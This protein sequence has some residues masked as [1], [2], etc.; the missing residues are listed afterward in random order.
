MKGEL[1]AIYCRLSVEDAHK[2]D[3]QSESIRNQRALLLDYAEGQGWEVVRVYADEDYSGLREDRPAFR[4]MLADAQ[5]G[6]F[7]ILLCKT[8]SRF[9]RNAQTAEKYLH[10]LF[11][12]WG[13]RFVTVV[14][15]VDTAYRAN[16]KA[17]QINSLV[18]EW[19][20]EELSENIRAVLRRK[21]QA[22]QFL[23]NYPPY[24]YRRDDADRHHLLPD[25][26]TAPVVARI[27][28]R[29]LAGGSCRKI[30]AGLTAEGVPTP[31]QLKK[32]RGEDLGRRCAAAWSSSTVRKIL[33]NPLYLGHMVQGREEKISFKEKKTRTLPQERWIIVEHTHE[34][35]VEGAVFEEVAR[36]MAL[37]RRSGQAEA[38]RR[39]TT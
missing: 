21:M 20:C 28:S 1:A 17:R 25:A 33:K 15:H 22:G 19:Y 31:S 30:A 6:Q 24:G 34:P 29:Y 37:R 35:L 2:E 3:T 36:R 18:N 39:K 14:D 5:A 7:S 13:L 26:E 32:S 11:P 12:L 8:Q 10:E 27:F 9:T 38:Q 16:K 23:G 4:Q